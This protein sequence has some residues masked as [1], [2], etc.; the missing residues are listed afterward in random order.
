MQQW[1]LA[2]RKQQ[3]VL[4]QS[5][6]WSNYLC[7]HYSMRLLINR[8]VKGNAAGKGSQQPLRNDWLT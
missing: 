4:Q 2:T 6:N 1:C 7:M 5:A 3:D 8:L